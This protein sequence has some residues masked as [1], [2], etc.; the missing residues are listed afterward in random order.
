MPDEPPAGR[1]PPDPGASRQHSLEPG[2]RTCAA[3]LRHE[4]VRRAAGR[5]D[6]HLVRRSA[7][8]RRRTRRRERARGREYWFYNGGRPAG[9]AITID[10]PATDARATIWAAFKHDVRCLLLARRA[11]AAQLAETGGARSERLGRD[12][13]LRQSRTAEQGDRGRGL[14]P[15]RRR[16]AVSG[17]G[18]PASGGGSWHRGPDRDDPARELPPRPAGSSVPDARE[19]ARPRQRRA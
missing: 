9:G 5:G 15:R 3:D 17:R 2:A 12:H 4:Q 11:L 7:G 19:K 10:A 16:P 1:L 6:R 8:L 13:H 18:A 14:H